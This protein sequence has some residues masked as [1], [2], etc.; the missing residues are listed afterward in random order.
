M[1]SSSFAAL[2]T[3]LR[4][5]H[6]RL[7]DLLARGGNL[8]RVAAEMNMTQ[9]AASKIL[10][11]AEILLGVRLFER[12]PRAM[13]PTEIGAF[14]A[15]YAARTLREADSFADGLDNLKAG[16]FGA[17]AIG[18][19]MATTPGLLPKAIAELKRRRPLMTIQLLAATSDILLDALERNEI[20]MALGRFTDPSNALAFDLEPLAHEELWIFVAAQHPLAHVTSLT[21]GETAHMPWVLQQKTSPMRQLIDR[22]FVEAGVGTLNNLV[23]T[24]SIF[25]TLHLVREAG[26]IAC[27]P[28][29]ILM[30]GVGRDTFKRLPI[31]LPNQLGP[32]GIITRR[33][34][35]PSANVADFIDVLHEIA[36]RERQTLLAG[37]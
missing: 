3:R 36:A 9:P 32:L 16:G 4:F 18:A 13:L 35:T 10:Q 15:D 5:R 28:K 27:L 29:S 22:A 23:E 24:T 1:V 33:G 8:H 12:T 14:V 34:E 25:A 19:I 20:S 2:V 11:D 7:I 30:E 31:E 26:M 6:L 21:L 37:F 17:L